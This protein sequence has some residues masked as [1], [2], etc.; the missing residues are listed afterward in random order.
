MTAPSPLLM[1][2]DQKFWESM[3]L[4][5]TGDDRLTEQERAERIAIVEAQRVPMQ[6][7]IE[8]GRRPGSERAA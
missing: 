8:F 7:A 1:P 6:V 4:W 3:G 5:M 2:D